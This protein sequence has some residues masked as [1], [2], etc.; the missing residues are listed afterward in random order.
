MVKPS[1][2]SLFKLKGKNLLKS[3]NHNYIFVFFA[4]LMLAIVSVLVIWSVV[5]LVSELTKPFDDSGVPVPTEK[6]DIKGFEELNLI[7]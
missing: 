4:L 1:L 3:W 6:F 7:R 5:F 2:K